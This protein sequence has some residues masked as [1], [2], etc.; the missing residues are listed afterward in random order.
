MKK[1]KSEKRF[2]EII[3]YI[4]AALVILMFYLNGHEI[5]DAIRKV[6]ISW[7]LI[8]L[9]CYF[10]NYLLRAY[11]LRTLSRLRF[12]IWP[13][14]IR[15]ACVHG[16][17]T[18][19]L[20]FRTG[21]LTLPMLLKSSAGIELKE[22]GWIL[23]K[24]RLLDLSAL[25]IITVVSAVCLP[26]PI[27]PVFRWGWIATG[28]ALALCPWVL[29]CLGNLGNMPTPKLLQR[30]LAFGREI[31]ISR[32]ELVE[33][34]GIWMAVGTCYYCTA[35]A[36][37][38]PLDMGGVWFLVTVQ[39]PLQLIPLRG[40]ANAGNHEGGWLAA[41]SLLGFSMSEG[42][43]F[44]LTSHAILLTYVLALG[45]ASVFIRAS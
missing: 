9:C 10:A 22:G 7:F 24:A 36:V 2:Q 33:S 30:I 13:Q 38:L 15:T 17:A 45:A 26:I 28:L 5:W 27:Q 39:L 42:L 32:R 21:D 25:G 23:V 11:R 40:V 3:S 18:Y 31:T 29:K 16:F 34:L 41:L 6:N 43:N 1:E 44:A 19:I 20:P 8:G 12:S 14:G 35:K 4:I 37:D